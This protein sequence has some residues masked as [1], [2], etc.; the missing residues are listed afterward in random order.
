MSLNAPNHFQYSCGL[1][2]RSSPQLRRSA[3][4]QNARPVPVTTTT[5]TSSSHDASSHA[6]ASSRSMRKSN[7]LRTSG[8]FSRI[9]ARGGVLLV[10]DR[11]E[12]ELGRVGAGGGVWARSLGDLGEVHLKRDAHLHRVLAR[13]P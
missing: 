8:R 3:P 11:L 12:A 4:T 13:W 7:A 5:R 9:V 10:D 1:P 6:R 2:S